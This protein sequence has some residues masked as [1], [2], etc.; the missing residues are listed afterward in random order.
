MKKIIHSFLHFVA[1]TLLFTMSIFVYANASDGNTDFTEK[2]KNFFAEK[3]HLQQ[4]GTPEIEIAYGMDIAIPNAVQYP[5]I[6]NDAVDKRVKKIVEEMRG[7]AILKCAAEKDAQHADFFITYESY[8]TKGNIYSVTFHEVHHYDER[9]FFDT[10]SFLFD[11][12]T[13]KEIAPSDIFL[14]AYQEKAA[15]YTA[16]LLQES[17]VYTESLPEDWKERLGADK[18]HFATYA[19][20]DTSMIFYI[21]KNDVFGENTGILTIEVPRKIFA[22]YL[23]PE[24]KS[25]P[26]VKKEKANTSK[27]RSIDPKKPMV[28]LTYDDG[29]G[30]AA[31]NHILDTLEKYGVVAT[32]FDTGERVERYPKTVQREVALGCEVAS[33]SY[34]HKDFK[35]LTAAQIK[36]DVQRTDAAFQKAIGRKPTL[37]RPPYGNYNKT[38]QANIPYPIIIWSVDTLDWKSRNADS[39]LKSIQKVGD[40]DGKVILMHGIYDSTAKATEKLVPDLLKKGYQLVTVSELIQYRLNE[41]PVKGK[42]YHQSHFQ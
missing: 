18:G 7:N 34:D 12:K 10:H 20:K 38:V 37:F 28:A 33:H 6:G 1:L 13:G 35:K 31:T 14:P 40:L 41:T 32:F 29:P 11:L 23:K 3:Q 2:A 19:L 26:A 30:G 36:A 15:S 39:V 8:R 9:N 27:K 4:A 24:K 21:N 17:N 16:S 22:D 5:R 25:P 42:V